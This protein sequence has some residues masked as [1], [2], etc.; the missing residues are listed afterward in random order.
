MNY[1]DLEQAWRSPRNQPSAD[2]LEDA[3][4]TFTRALQRRRRQTLIVLAL[5]FL[6]LAVCTW[7]LGT[8]FIA[9]D[10]P[11]KAF[12]PRH[13]WSVLLLL[14]L[15][16]AAWLIL[17][18]LFRRGARRGAAPVAISVSVSRLLDEN[19]RQR[20][21]YKV[22]GSL[23]ALCALLLPLIVHQLRS[24]GKVGDEVVVPA[25]VIFPLYVGAFVIWTV[26]YGRRKLAP[27]ACELEALREAYRALG[28]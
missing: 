3:R 9:P 13:E 16:W 14:A 25:F 18:S 6:P 26:L 5:S 11:L 21:F 17:L 4:R 24:V 12:S 22:M 20:T 1:A 27:R 15:S 19:R 2:E 8:H 28:H 23:L 10:Q 7:V